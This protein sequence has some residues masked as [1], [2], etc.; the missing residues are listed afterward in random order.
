MLI[1]VNRHDPQVKAELDESFV[2]AQV[3]GE[4]ANYEDQITRVIVNVMDRNADKGG[5]DKHCAMEIR[6]RGLK[7]MAVTTEAETVEAAVVSASEK[8]RRLVEHE[9]GRLQDRTVGS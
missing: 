2:D 1:E 6:I 3:R 8:A 4:L 9:L 7:P 5:V